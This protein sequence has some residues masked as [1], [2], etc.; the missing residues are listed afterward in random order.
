M[1][2]VIAYIKPHKLDKIMLA[3]YAIKGLTGISL[4]EIQGSGRGYNTAPEFI[5]DVEN[6]GLEPHIKLEIACHDDKVKQVIAAIQE[7]AHTDLR[8]DGKIYVLPVLEAIR[9]SSGETG[10]IAI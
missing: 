10:E 8:G 6:Y 2:Q 5:F 7:S 1:K 4:L 9:I 3:L